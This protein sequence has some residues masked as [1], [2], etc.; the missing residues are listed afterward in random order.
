MFI[1][2]S[3]FAKHVFDPGADKSKPKVSNWLLNFYA[4]WQN[5]A[6]RL[7][8]APTRLSGVEAPEVTPID[9]GPDGGSHPAVVTS[10]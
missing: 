9:T 3:F 7:T 5:P 2:H 10:S 6:R 4:S 8:T 1:R